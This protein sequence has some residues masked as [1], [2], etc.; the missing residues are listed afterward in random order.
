MRTV[1][2]IQYNPKGQSWLISCEPHVTIRLKRVFG[3]ISK[4][5]QGIHALTD[6]MENARD[7]EW[8]LQRY[9]MKMQD[10]D[11]ELLRFRS[12][13]HIEQQGIIQ[14]LMQEQAE[15]IDFPLAIPAREYQRLAATLTLETGRLLLADDVG[16]GKAQPNES[17]VLTPNGWRRIDELVV[18]DKVIDPDGGVGIVEGVFPQGVKDIYRVTTQDGASADRYPLHLEGTPLQQFLHRRQDQ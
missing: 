15:P 7:L 5:S 11:A 14:R 17:L 12:L 6:T 1:G 8:F 16:T 18:G 9:P 2:E 4:H 3:K 13:A 10:G